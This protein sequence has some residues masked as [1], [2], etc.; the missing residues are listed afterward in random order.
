M[1]PYLESTSWALVTLTLIGG[2]CRLFWD[3]FLYL[4]WF[5]ISFCHILYNFYT[6][7]KGNFYPSIIR[8]FFRKRYEEAQK[9]L[10][11]IMK[12]TKSKGDVEILSEK[13]KS[14]V[15]STIGNTSENQMQVLYSQDFR[16]F[17]QIL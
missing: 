16:K 6:Q 7:G 14:K 11:T 13:L 15:T 1:K 9:T 10:T 8:F 17:V 2:I 12:W 4:S 3:C 5:Y